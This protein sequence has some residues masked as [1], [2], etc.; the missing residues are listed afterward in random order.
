[1]TI[2]QPGQRVALVHTSD[3]HTDLRPGDTGTVRRHDQQLNTVHIDWDSGSSLSMCLDAGDRIEPF[4]PAVPDTRPSSDTDGWTSTLARLC[5][6]GDEAGR[7]VADWWAQDTIGGRATGDVRATARRILVGI[8]DGDPAVLDHLPTFTPPSRWH[9]DRDTAEVRYTEAAHD[10]APRRAPHWR[11]L[12]DT[13]RD[14]TIAASQEAFEAAV[15]ERVAELCRLAASPTGADMSHLHPE[16]VRIGLVGVFAGEWAWSVD[17]E[18]ADRVPV[19]FLGTLIDRWNGWAVFACTR[20]V[21]EAIVADQQRQRRASR[22]SLQAKGV[23]EAELDRRVNAELTELRFEG[24]VIVA[25]QRA[26]YDDPEAIEHIGPD[27]DGRYVV[28]GWN[29]CWQA[30]DPYDCD[31]IVGDLPEPGREQEFELLRHTPGLRV[32]HTRLQLTDV[33][34]RPASTGLAFTATLALDGPPIATVTDDGAGAITVDPD[35]LTATHGGLRAYLAECRFQGSPVGMPRLL[36]AL[37][38]EH[39]LSQAVAQAEADGGTQLRLVD[40]TGHTRALRPIAP[41]PADLTP[42]LELG[43]TLTRGPGQ[44]WQI[45]TGA[46]WFTVPGALTRP[47]QPHDRNC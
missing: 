46:S 47:G 28:M 10:A 41:A 8:D 11:D 33:R 22:A 19:G 43:R 18:G 6:L 13:Q 40:D 44:Q 21:A 30:V 45:W 38:D 20:E 31:R 36:Q 4:D 23:A 39:F 34:Y 26:Q 35:D 1:M 2:Y 32:P 15:H 9:D 12:T 16:R 29:W 14:E 27:A 3:P 42:L 25:D 7:D 37:A 5:A 17:A 24:E